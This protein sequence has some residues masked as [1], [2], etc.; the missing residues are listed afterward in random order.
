MKNRFFLLMILLP[1]FLSG[2]TLREEYL[3]A[4]DA[5][6]FL[7][8]KQLEK[9]LLAVLG[10]ETDPLIRTSLK[11][12]LFIERI[13]VEEGGFFDGSI[14]ALAAAGDDIWAGSRSGDLGRYSLSERKWQMMSVGAPSLAVRAVN[15]ILPGSGRIWILSYGSLAW[16][17]L[18]TGELNQASLPDHPDYRG[19]QSGVL[20]GDGLLAGTQGG[21]L[22]RIR[23]DGGAVLEMPR[24][25][26]NVSYI[27]RIG[28]ERIL[29]GTEENGLFFL[30]SLRESRPVTENNR[31]TSA[32][33][34]ILGT[35]DSFLGGSYGQGLFSL[36]RDEEGHYE[37]RRL[38]AAGKWITDGVRLKGGY[39][40][41]TLG[42]GLIYLSAPDTAPGQ[43]GIPEGLPS[44]DITALAY[45]EP[46]IICG[47]QGQGLIKI[48]ENY[49][50]TP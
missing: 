43:F 11:R 42:S 33:R 49:F 44:L 50:L 18:R 40:F 14:S 39:C 27:A 2:Q 41:S 22:R 37:Y 31:Q 48:H 20:L 29:L 36:K 30:D 25:I 8:E 34:T 24:F 23:A 12:A 17:D 46:Y 45:S 32:V 47:T 5:G 35:G 16:Y 6:D 13:P 15:S 10:A 9:E 7:R 26:R 4:R 21:G 19:M 1:V 3:A 38:S 28:P